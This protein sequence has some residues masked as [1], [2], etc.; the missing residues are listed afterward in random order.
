MEG[1]EDAVCMKSLLECTG[2]VWQKLDKGEI[3]NSCRLIIFSEHLLLHLTHPL[4]TYPSTHPSSF[5]SSSFHPSILSPLLL[6]QS[7]SI[8]SLKEIIFKKA[9]EGIGRV[10]RGKIKRFTSKKLSLDKNGTKMDDDVEGIVRERVMRETG[11]VVEA[12]RV[13]EMLASLMLLQG[14]S[15][16]DVI[17]LLLSSRTVCGLFAET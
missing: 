13:A 1:Y 14:S 3:L 12:R 10:R 8:N 15:T 6:K 2:Q 9:K 7:S 17:D 16:S 11:S 4:S 5:N